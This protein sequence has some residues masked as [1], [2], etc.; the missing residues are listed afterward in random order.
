M[1]SKPGV[2]CECVCERAYARGQDERGAGRS[3]PQDSRRGVMAHRQRR[4]RDTPPAQTA[5][6]V[7]RPTCAH[8][9]VRGLLSM[10]Q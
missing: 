7:C 2:A 5:R 3:S 8:A 4:S 10:L 6:A 1:L 9:C